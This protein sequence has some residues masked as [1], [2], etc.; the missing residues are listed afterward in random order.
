MREIQLTDSQNGLSEVFD[1]IERLAAGCRFSNCT[2]GSEP[3]C[4]VQAAVAE[5]RL[6]PSRLAR[7]MKLMAEEQFNTEM[8][9]ET[10]SRDRAFGR[11]VRTVMQDKRDKGKA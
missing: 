1:D 6:D 10:R 3:G 7:W 5:D 8:L 11:M 4:A 9:A 2:H